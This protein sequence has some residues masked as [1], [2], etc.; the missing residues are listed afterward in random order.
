M[1]K[2]EKALNR[3][4]GKERTLVKDLLTRLS[5]GDALGLNIVR[6]KGHSDIFRLRKGDL[7]IIYRQAGKDISVLTVERRSE[8]TY[9][10]F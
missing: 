3:L 6:L 7:R 10:D 1:D 4:S 5:K 8:K 2:I 9:R